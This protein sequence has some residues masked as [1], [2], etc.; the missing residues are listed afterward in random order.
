MFVASRFTALMM[1]SIFFK[2]IIGVRSV[3]H[4]TIVELHFLL[5]VHFEI[6]PVGMNPGTIGLLGAN[7]TQSAGKKNQLRPH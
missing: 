4:Q 7:Q 6:T 1:S 5:I 2:Q 3:L